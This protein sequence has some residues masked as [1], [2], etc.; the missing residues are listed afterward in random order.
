MVTIQICIGSACHLKGSYKVIHRIQD[1]INARGLS[2]RVAI[3]PTFC[4]G[5]CARA[6]S[7]RFEGEDEVHSVSPDSAEAFFEQQVMNRLD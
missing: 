1:E 4:L 2:E 6:V 7:V 5:E 3:K